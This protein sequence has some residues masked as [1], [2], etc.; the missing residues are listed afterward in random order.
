MRLKLLE[1]V[2]VTELLPTETYP[3]LDLTKAK[4]SIIRLSMVGKEST[5]KEC[6]DLAVGI[7]P[8]FFM[9]TKKA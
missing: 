6:N 5:A 4:Y 1:S 3:S 9:G 8:K 7:K 2:I